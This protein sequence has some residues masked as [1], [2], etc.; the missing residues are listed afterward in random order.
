ME[1]KALAGGERQV[2]PVAAGTTGLRVAR[3]SAGDPQLAP[4]RHVGR[5]PRAQCF[6]RSQATT[7]RGS[8][9]IPANPRGNPEDAGVWIASQLARDGAARADTLLRPSHFTKAQ[10][11]NAIKGFDSATR[12]GDWLVDSQHWTALR[13]TCAALID[14]EH[15]SAPRTPRTAAGSTS[16]SRRARLQWPR[17]FEELLADLEQNGLSA[18]RHTSPNAIIDPPCPRTCAMPA[19]AFA[20]RCNPPIRLRAKP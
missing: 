17:M 15:R 12:L 8:S 9:R 1:G 7:H 14:E 5:R 20:P 19:N 2:G 16:P 6:R 10:I 13:E 18:T 11:E 3:R 4:E